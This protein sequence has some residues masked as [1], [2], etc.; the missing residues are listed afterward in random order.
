M[1]KII[2][3][4]DDLTIA[5]SLSQYVNKQ[6]DMQCEAVYNTAEDAI[7]GIIRIRPTIVLTD[8]GL[9][10]KSGLDI[11]YSVLKVQPT[12][13]FVV[14]TVFDDNETLFDALRKGAVGYLLKDESKDQ[15]VNGIRDVYAGG[16]SMTPSIARKVM[17]S[18]HR[19]VAPL[20]VLT[21]HQVTLLEYL[22]EGLLNKEIAAR[23]NIKEASVKVQISR[24]YQKLQVNNRVEA[25]NLL[26][27]K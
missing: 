22:A 2:I 19:S 27:Q 15:I 14:Y 7:P 17:N 11:I 8:I 20:E 25:V 23:L 13:K 9:P 10:H 3:V 6:T 18:F 5:N 21:A 26:Y 24:I 16:A 12:I 1:I 4:E